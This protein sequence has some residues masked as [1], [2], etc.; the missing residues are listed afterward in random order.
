MNRSIDGTESPFL[1]ELAAEFG[2][3]PAELVAMLRRHLTRLAAGWHGPHAISESVSVSCAEQFR[4]KKVCFSGELRRR[5]LGTPISHDRARSLALLAGLRPV[6]CV[7][8]DLDIL[9]VTDS[10]ARSKEVRQARECGAIVLD[11]G[12]FWPAIGHRVT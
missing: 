3:S 4:D 7:T 2:I 11:E 1:N 12:V 5:Y 9:V 8:S 10:W 6:E